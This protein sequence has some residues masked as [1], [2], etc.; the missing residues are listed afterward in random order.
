[1]VPP[2]LPPWPVDHNILQN[3]QFEEFDS[4]R[5]VS[6]YFRSLDTN[7]SSQT[8][9]FYHPSTNTT[10][11]QKERDDFQFHVGSLHVFFLSFFIYF[12]LNIFWTK[13]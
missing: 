12:F 9:P 8:T 3:A 4:T 10:S 7:G 13:N 6:T 1:M 5:D 2:P 11:T